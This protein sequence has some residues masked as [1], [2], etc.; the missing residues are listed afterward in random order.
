MKVDG[1]DIEYMNRHSGCYGTCPPGILWYMHTYKFGYLNL[2]QLFDVFVAGFSDDCPYHDIRWFMENGCN[3]SA[4]DKRDFV[5]HLATVIG[6]VLLGWSETYVQRHIKDVPEFYCYHS[7][8]SDDKHRM[9]HLIYAIKSTGEQHH[10]SYWRH[11]HDF[12]CTARIK[13][14]KNDY[15][16]ATEPL[17]K[18]CYDKYDKARK[19][20]M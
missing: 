9:R 4:A 13:L 12:F 19:D 18:F 3:M 6:I 14:S 1:F 17:R 20:A 5:L 2:K 8:Y 7:F 15:S 10:Y 16:F 11:I